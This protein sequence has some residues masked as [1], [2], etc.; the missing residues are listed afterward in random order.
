MINRS[1]DIS[2]VAPCSSQN[3]TKRNHQPLAHLSRLVY[4][5]RRITTAAGIAYVQEP[6]LAL[7]QH[8]DRGPS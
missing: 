3:T 7:A 5:S 1:V 8:S 6:V 2:K 4:T